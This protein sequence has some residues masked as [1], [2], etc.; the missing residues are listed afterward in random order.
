[1]TD[2]LLFIGKLVVTGGVGIAAFYIFSR[3]VPLISEKIPTVNYYLAP[4]IIITIATF[5]IAS[6]FFSVYTM[7]VDTLFLCFLE[8]CE[9][10]DGS[11]EKP[12]F[13]SKDL[14]KILDKHNLKAKEE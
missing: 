14:M 11:A 4:V 12:Y 1:M 2:F 3:D 13:M 6:A 10:N 7:A 8:D 9:R 5:F